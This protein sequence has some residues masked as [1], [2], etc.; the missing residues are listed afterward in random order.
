VPT[1]FR[2]AVNWAKARGLTQPFAPGNRFRPTLAASRG[3]VVR[4]LH[5]LSADQ[6]SW[7]AWTRPPVST[8]SFDDTDVLIDGRDFVPGRTTVPAGETVTWS[9]LDSEE[10]DVTFAGPP[11][12]T[13]LLEEG[14]SGHRTFP[15]A[16]TFP[17]TCELHPGMNGVVTVT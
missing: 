5:D 14:E 4:L 9:N 11:S 10:H 12:S 17:Y 1:T 16:G 2:Q 13:V 6:L 15:T 7:V 3:L 8:W